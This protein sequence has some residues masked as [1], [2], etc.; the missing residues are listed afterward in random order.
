MKGLKIVE[1][2]KKS[3]YFAWECIHQEGWHTY[4]LH[5]SENFPSVFWIKPPKNKIKKDGDGGEITLPETKRERANRIVPRVPLSL[6]LPVGFVLD[7]HHS[8][9]VQ[10]TGELGGV[11]NAGE[12][13]PTTL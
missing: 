13:G 1:R 9:Q 10:E 11:H 7:H 6:S 8:S 12:V 4:K 2:K 3:M 5:A